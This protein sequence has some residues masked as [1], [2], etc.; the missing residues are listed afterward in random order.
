M[1]KQVQEAYIVAATRSPIGKSGRGVFRN[2]RSDDL[3]IATI[4]SALKQ[5][6]SLDPKAID[7][8]GRSL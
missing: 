5:V 8:R 6:P 3:L 7:A 4:Q 1:S 2:M